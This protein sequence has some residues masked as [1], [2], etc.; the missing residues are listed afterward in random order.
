MAKKAKK[1]AAKTRHKAQQIGVND[2][3]NLVRRCGSLKKQGRTLAGEAGEMI[4]NAIENKNLDRV[5]FAIFRKL[6]DMAVEKLATTLACLDYYIDVGGL[7]KKIDDQP[8]LNI[9]RQEAGEK[10]DGE[11][12]QAP[13]L[14]KRKKKLPENVIEMTAAE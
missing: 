8:Q 6:D 9:A 10:E 11:P 5:A 3:K 7:Q 14:R 1:T 4:K 2:F 12:S 13:P